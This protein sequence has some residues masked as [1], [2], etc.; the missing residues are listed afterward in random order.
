MATYRLSVKLISRSSGRSAT[1]A[2]AYRAGERIVDERTGEIF[3]YRR[4]SDVLD[5]AI[6]A[7]RGS[8]EWVR[9]RTALWNAAEA[10]ERRKDAQIAREI[11]V[12]LPHELSLKGNR[13]LLRAFIKEQL[14]DRGM[15]T[16]VAIHAAHRGSDERNI[17]A[18]ILLTTREM[19]SEGFGSKTRAWND[20]ALLETWRAEWGRH[21]NRALEL[22]RV[23][24][25]VDHR[26]YAERGIDREPEPKQGYVA[27]K[28]ERQGRHSHAGDD[29][30]AAK[31]RNAERDRFH[32][33]RRRVDEE[34]RKE[35][36][37]RQAER[38]HDQR[39]QESSDRPHTEACG[40]SIGSTNRP[41]WQT[42]REH[43][44]SEAY[45]REMQGSRLARF[46]RIERTA[47]GL[48]FEN[49]RGW[50]EDQGERV[51]ARDGNDLEIRGMLDVAA[52]K[53]WSELTFSGSDGFKRRAMAEAL[54]RGFT[55]ATR[56]RDA[57]LL[58]SV[59]EDRQ[60]RS[61]ATHAAH[62]YRQSGRV[63]RDADYERE[64]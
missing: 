42:W 19:T 12:S 37:H 23:R 11:Q 41:R 29:R 43:V 17:H 60:S 51:V 55:I 25:R 39:H 22:A 45:A 16:D 15:V 31:S 27:T 47:R 52:A 5:R 21:V 59:K 62:D 56:G 54:D 38:D 36:N 32:D 35:K 50:F 58:R 57:K 9:N 33:E 49:A 3:D 64:R 26:S 20:R 34:V 10:A 44:L 2:A 7:P 40:G 24:A 6:L 46:W 63:E 1:A 4:R 13:A 14:T 53:G 18:H 8:P 48:A 61:G 28:M 30:R